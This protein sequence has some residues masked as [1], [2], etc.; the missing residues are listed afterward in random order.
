MIV[1]YHH[2]IDV[3]KINL[4]WLSKI[5]WPTQ[6]WNL[7]AADPLKAK[8]MVKEVNKHTPTADWNHTCTRQ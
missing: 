4:R 6:I 2:C 7:K 3:E 8:E 5:A 1:I